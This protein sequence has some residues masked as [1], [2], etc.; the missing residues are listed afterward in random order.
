M[1]RLILKRIV[2]LMVL[3]AVTGSVWAKGS[4]TI[5]T[6]EELPLQRDKGSVML[7]VQIPSFSYNL[8]GIDFYALHNMEGIIPVRFSDPIPAMSMSLSYSPD[9]RISFGGE[10]RIA[11][12]MYKPEFCPVPDRRIVYCTDVFATIGVLS[13]VLLFSEGEC[14]AF[15]EGA[16]M[17]GA[18]W[19]TNLSWSTLCPSIG[20]SGRFHVGCS[21][22]TLA[23]GIEAAAALDVI[24]PKE[25]RTL[26][27]SIRPNIALVWRWA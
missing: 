26:M 5:D 21:F 19:R 24:G 11:M 13:P 14:R 2:V 17:I 20:V 27:F 18:S 3:I 9:D 16:L 12:E 8:S 4:I 25:E 1:E 23:F 10:I 7:S 15:V 22:I 6:A